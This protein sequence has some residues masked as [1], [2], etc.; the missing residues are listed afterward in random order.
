MFTGNFDQ[1]SNRAD[2]VVE[3]ALTEDGDPYDVTDATEITITVR[4]PESKEEV[5][6]GTLSDGDIFLTDDGTSATVTIT[7][8]SPG[9]VSWTDH[10][11]TTDNIVKFS[12]SGALPTGIT[13]DTIY[14]VLASGL[15][16]NTFQIAATLGGTA[17]NTTGSQSGTHTAQYG[18]SGLIQWEF[19][20]SDMHALCA[21]SYD[22]GAVLETSDGKKIQI[23]D[24]HLPVYDGIVA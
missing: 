6:S 12:T 14:F 20:E 13:A 19:P 11:L 17:I 7:I 1:T 9:V 22:V 18:Q 4:D 23:I 10:G 15:T 24:A 5:L 21:K 3:Y 8:A 2:W 16:D